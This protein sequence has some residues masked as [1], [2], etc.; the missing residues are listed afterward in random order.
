MENT[1]YIPFLD[2]DRN[3]KRIEMGDMV[4]GVDDKG[5]SVYG[6]VVDF[7]GFYLIVLDSKGK[8]HYCSHDN[9]IIK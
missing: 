8:R 6:E 7:T 5:K 4:T 2:Y 3:G 1:I 9:V